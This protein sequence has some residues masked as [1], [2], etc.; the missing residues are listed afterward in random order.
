MLM[1]VLQMLG[2]IGEIGSLIYTD[3][4][5]FGCISGVTFLAE[6]PLFV[7]SLWLST[8]WI[9]RARVILQYQSSPET[10]DTSDRRH[11]VRRAGDS[12]YGFL[13]DDHATDRY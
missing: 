2:L 7:L 13:S 9:Y 12:D 11:I 4:S 5:T 1:L 3:Y 6:Y 10:I 8:A